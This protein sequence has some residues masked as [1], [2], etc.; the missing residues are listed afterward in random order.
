MVNVGKISLRQFVEYI[1]LFGLFSSIL[2]PPIPLGQYKF[3]A[4]TLISPILFICSL[5]FYRFNKIVVLKFTFILFGMGVM[6]MVSNFYSSMFL[7][8][9][10]VFSD[11][12][13]IIKF[14]QFIPYAL[15]LPFLSPTSLFSVTRSWILPI[16]VWV[17][18]LGM[19][20]LFL[21]QP[22][23]S[24]HLSLYSIDSFHVEGLYGARRIFTTGSDPNMGGAIL[25]FF[26][27]F[28]FSNKQILKNLYRVPL[29]LILC[30]LFLNT[31]S[32]TSILGA[33]L[34]VGIYMLLT[35]NKNFKLKILMGILIFGFFTLIFG[36]LNLDYI[37]EG[38]DLART[39]NN[40]SL[41]LRLK[42]IIMA[43]NRFFDS[44]IFGWGTAKTMHEVVI[45]SEYALIL[46]RYGILGITV[47]SSLYYFLFKNS[48]NSIQK[49]IKPVSLMF[50]M[51]SLVFMTTNNIFSGYQL[52]SIVILLYSLNYTNKHY[53]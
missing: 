17:I 16:L 49:T 35:I 36:S 43:I 11:Y 27:V 25:F 14:W 52:M 30:Y 4:T 21:L 48:I 24:M 19:I 26:I 20:Q 31:Q 1:F 18:Y 22:F 13:E 6:I 7:K 42:Y 37:K 46:Q 2:L 53:V 40:E 45:D 29:L 47:F 34:S 33:I 28:L 10:L 3:F 9:G 39:G 38:I 44:P 32:R 5:L 50:L 41:N 12:M 15:V 8:T 23:L 51:F